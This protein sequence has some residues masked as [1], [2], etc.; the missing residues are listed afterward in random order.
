MRPARFTKGDSYSKNLKQSHTRKLGDGRVG[1][2]VPV[3]LVLKLTQEDGQ[4]KASM[5][6]RGSS[7]PGW[8]AQ[9]ALS[10]RD[11]IDP[12]LHYIPPRPA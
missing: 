10:G 7:M 3:I 12:F 9:K 6:Y 8:A 4:F 1:Y 11:L 5:S 2:G